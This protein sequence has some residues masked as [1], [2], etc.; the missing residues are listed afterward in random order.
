MGVLVIPE[1]VFLPFRE[2]VARDGTDDK[3]ND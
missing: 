2:Q 3:G 1:F